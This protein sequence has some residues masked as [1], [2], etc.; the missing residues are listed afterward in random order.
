VAIALAQ[1]WASAIGSGTSVALAYPSS[2]SA[3]S[4]LT[5]CVGSGDGGTVLTSITDGQSNP[6]TIDQKFT[7]GA[8]IEASISSMPNAPG[9]ALTV[10]ANLSASAFASNLAI[11]EGSGAAT[12][13]PKDQSTGTGGFSSAPSSGNVTTLQDGEW[14]IGVACS[15]IAGA[16]HSGGSLANERIDNAGNRPLFVQ[17]TIGGAIGTYASSST[18]TGGNQN[19]AACISTYKALAARPQAASRLFLGVGM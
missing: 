7:Q 10:T 5:A 19:W 17:D 13:S 8:A 2:T 12:S 4:L 1:A 9:G 3:A 11:G 6:W 15:T 16:T 18:V 14:I